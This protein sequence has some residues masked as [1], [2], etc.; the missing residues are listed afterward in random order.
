MD[1]LVT[2]HHQLHIYPAQLNSAAEAIHAACSAAQKPKLE[3]LN[4]AVHA[5]EQSLEVKPVGGE[6]YKPRAQEE[7][8][9]LLLDVPMLIKYA[10]KMVP[11]RLIAERHCVKDTELEALKDYANHLVDCNGPVPESA[12]ILLSRLMWPFHAREQRAMRDALMSLEPSY[13]FNAAEIEPWVTTLWQWHQVWS[14]IE[15]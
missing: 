6:A 14:Q 5:M 7:V 1:S 12:A 10:L 4:K 9:S 13:G 15:I 8:W 2:T 11:W 3:A